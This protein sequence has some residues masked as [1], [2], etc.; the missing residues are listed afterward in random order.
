MVGL[1]TGMLRARCGFY[2]G[3]A[4]DDARRCLGTSEN[5]VIAL[6]RGT[7]EHMNDKQR[8]IVESSMNYLEMSTMESL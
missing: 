1:Y 4:I 2:S 8:L 3:Q 7:G 5:D 6:L